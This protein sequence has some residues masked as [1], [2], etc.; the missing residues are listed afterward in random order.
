MVQKTET[1]TGTIDRFLFQGPDNG[2]T[3]CIVNDTKKNKELIAKGYLPNLQAGQ[4]VSLIGNW[5]F[6]PKFGKQFE[7]Q[8]Y[9]IT[10]PTS[11]N[12]L[13]KYLGSG[14]IKGIGPAYAEKLVNHFGSEIL[15]IINEQPHRLNEVPGIGTKRIEQIAASW[16]QQREVSNIMVFLQDKEISTNYA[17]KIYKKYGQNSVAV[18]QENPYRLA[19]EIWG[20]GFKVADAIASKLGIAHDSLKRIRS[21]ISYAIN[22]AVGQGHLYVE[23]ENLRTQVYEIL[24]LNQ[25][26]HGTKLKQALHELHQ[27]ETIKVIKHNDQHFIT[28]SQFLFTEKAI[29]KKIN[30]MLATPTIYQFDLDK[31]Y[32]QMR[33]QTGPV[34]LND[35]QQLATLSALKNKVTIITGGP[36]TGK[37][38]LIKQLL[39]ILD[40]NQISYKL[41]AP[42]GRAAKRISESTSKF[43]A[44]I[45]RL[46]EFDVSSMK[47]VHNEHNTLSTP[48][49]IID[50]ASMIDT[51]LINSILKALSS[52]THL[53]LIGDIDQLPSVGA[54]NVLSDLIKST[55]VPYT[56]LT[57]IFRQAQNSL[58]ITNAHRVNQGE[59]PTTQSND[60]TQKDFI[61]IKEDLPENL[62]T[63]LE[64]IIKKVLIR[65]HILPSRMV[66][67]APMH[68]GTAGTQ[69]INFDLQKLLNPQNLNLQNNDKIVSH[70]GYSYKTNDRVMQLKN[71]YDKNVFNGDIGTINE[72]TSDQTIICNYDGRLVEYEFSELDE[73]TLAYAISIHKSQGSEYEAVIIPIFTQHFTLLQRNLLYTAITRAKKLC[74]LIGQTRAIAMAVKNNKTIERKTFLKQLLTTELDVL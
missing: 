73:L 63:H 48:F 27:S 60:L 24:G 18:L 46:L 64:N 61:F 20:I 56:K 41:A 8:K 23:L 57:E 10:L 51:F 49:L 70:S 28:L 12:G 16:Q 66:V 52:N 2:F 74:I 54:G 62:P 35:D 31:I 71:N 40:Q 53:I 36:G 58:I 5:I 13:K 17:I 19:D 6:H 39:A 11:P 44:T 4:E 26:E 47:F 7:V 38:T 32:H 59:F 33:A 30:L 9:Q 72:I 14:L 42:T 69:K 22:V 1:I 29:A 25:A 15:T 50:E 21:G 67:L 37:T 55:Q 45:H 43:A 34:Q 68:R 65:Y 3:V